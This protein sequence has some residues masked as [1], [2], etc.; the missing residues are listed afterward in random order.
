[1]T[2]N[3][4]LKHNWVKCT[5]CTP[6]G[7]RLLARFA[8]A[9]CSLRRVMAFRVR[10][11]RPSIGRVAGPLDRIVARTLYRD[12]TPLRIMTHPT[13]SRPR[14]RPAHD[15]NFVSQ[16]PHLARLCAHCPSC[17]R[18]PRPCCTHDRP[19]GGHARPCCAPLLARPGLRACSAFCVPAHPT[20]CHNT[21]CCIVT[22]F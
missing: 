11:Y 5:R 1:M 20:V 13:V 18:P 17:R 3:S 16:H 9:A 15:T 12:A 21:S 19:Y 6:K 10:Y 2:E 7:P 8:Q 14:G 4:A 22:Q